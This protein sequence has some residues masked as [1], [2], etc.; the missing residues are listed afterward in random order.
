[1]PNQNQT[2]R[3]C[4]TCRHYNLDRQ[5][6]LRYPPLPVDNR[7]VRYP[8]TQWDDTCGEWRIRSGLRS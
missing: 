5:F 1:M 2:P 8:R 7:H 4:G 3:Q 6:C